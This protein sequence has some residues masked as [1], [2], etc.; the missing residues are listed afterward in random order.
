MVTDR[1][2]LKLVYAAKQHRILQRDG[3]SLGAVDGGTWTEKLVVTS[4]RNSWRVVFSAGP[5]WDGGL[6]R[7]YEKACAPAIPEARETVYDALDRLGYGVRAGVWLVPEER[8]G[9]LRRLR[10]DVAGWARIYVATA[11]SGPDVVRSV[12][13]RMRTDLAEALKSGAGTGEIRR[14][15][16]DLARIEA[17][18]RALPSIREAVDAAAELS[19]FAD[20]CAHF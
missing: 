12:I 19:G 3:G 2:D 7:E 14:L 13:A 10:A 18:A 15:Q 20:A 8:T 16:K 4:V 6:D 17:D 9:D 11:E 5:S 1:A